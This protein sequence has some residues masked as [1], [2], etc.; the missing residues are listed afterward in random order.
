M[1]PSYDKVLGG[2]AVLLLRIIDSLPHISMLWVIL[3][4]YKFIHLSCL[5]GNSWGCIDEFKTCGLGIGPQETFRGCAYVYI[6]QTKDTEESAEQASD[7]QE[8]SEASDKH[9]DLKDN[10]FKRLLHL[11]EKQ[12]S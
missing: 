10:M 5:T 11:L 6:E 12:T 3:L 4:H 1:L 8:K 7:L 2:G 9:V